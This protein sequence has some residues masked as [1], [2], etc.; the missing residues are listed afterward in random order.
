M[1]AILMEAVIGRECLIGAGALVP[2]GMKIP[3]RRL[4][5]GSPARVVR[6]LTPQELAG[7]RRSE[8]SYARLSSRHRRS[9]RVVF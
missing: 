7:L 2:K 4:V 9:S 8:A 6:A 3:P 5:L 1:G